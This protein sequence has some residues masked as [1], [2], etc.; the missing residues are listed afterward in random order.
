M[1]NTM[2]N[3][4]SIAHSPDS[5]DAYMF[6][7]LDKK[8]ID[9]KG[10]DFK[11]ASDE[12]SKLNDIAL[13]GQEEYQILALSFATLFKL[14]DEYELM[15][16]G[17]SFG[18]KDYGPRIITAE[19]IFNRL[20]DT[21]TD[22]SKFKLAVPG[23]N[24]SGFLATRA[25]TKEAYASEFEYVFCSYNEVFD[26]IQNNKVDA[27]LLIHESQLKYKDL[28][29]KLIVDLGVW[30]YKKTNGL[31][32]PL[33]C[34]AIK[35]SCGTETIAKLNS[36]LKESIQWANQNFEEVLEYSRKF[37]KNDLDDANAAKYLD[38]YVNDTTV[39]LKEDDYKSIE[40]LRK[41]FK[42][43]N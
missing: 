10:F 2:T 16:S 38:M 15:P 39:S 32:M 43:L 34:N 3:Q 12:I 35:K 36:L 29:Y 5:D 14:E 30:W 31:T 25:F 6:Y 13:K 4:I 33:G 40:L 7:A 17:C 37:A 21:Q 19:K 22:L 20:T 28:G 18:G 26:L 8:K 23:K 1:T 42:E 24:T 27:S 9:L 11:L 41:Y